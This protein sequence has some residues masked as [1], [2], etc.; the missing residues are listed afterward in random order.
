MRVLQHS[1]V[2]RY[3]LRQQASAQGSNRS[4]TGMLHGSPVECQV[5]THVSHKIVPAM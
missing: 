2:L 1:V 4:R 5:A 3:V